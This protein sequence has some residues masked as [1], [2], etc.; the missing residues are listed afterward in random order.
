MRLMVSR[1]SN[2]TVEQVNIY[3]KNNDIENNK[4]IYCSPMKIKDSV[5]INETLMVLEMNNDK[6]KVIAVG[7]IKNYVWADKIYNIYTDRN[8]TRY[9]YKGNYRILREEMESIDKKYESIMKI[10]D[11]VLF[12]GKTHV[13]R[14]QGITEVPD[15]LYKHISFGKYKIMDLL[16]KMFKDQFALQKTSL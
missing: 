6:N 5:L 16:R 15:K 1:Y 13:K 3:R 12:K 14:G 10:F 4:S 2:E 8:Y 9:I 11:L 7:L